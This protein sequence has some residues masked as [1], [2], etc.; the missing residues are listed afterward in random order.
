NTFFLSFRL[1]YCL[2]KYFHQS[3]LDV[4]FFTKVASPHICH[5]NRWENIANMDNYS[6]IDIYKILFLQSRAQQL[7]GSLFADYRVNE[8]LCVRKMSNF[9]TRAENKRLSQLLTLDC[10][11]SA[12]LWSA[13][14]GIYISQN[15]LLQECI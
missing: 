9:F 2:H 11:L 1:N 10:I 6:N 12:S 5:L 14:K 8:T 3:E 7:R 13:W 4:P 15:Q